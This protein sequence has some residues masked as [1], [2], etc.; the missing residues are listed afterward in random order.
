MGPCIEI[1][2]ICQ[3]QQVPTT[4]CQVY[5]KFIQTICQQQVP[6]TSYV[7][8]NWPQEFRGLWA[9][10]RCGATGTG[11]TCEIIWH[12]FVAVVHDETSIVCH[13]F[14]CKMGFWLYNSVVWHTCSC[15]LA[16]LCLSFQTATLLDRFL[17]EEFLFRQVT[18]LEM[19]LSG[20]AL[21]FFGEKNGETRFQEDERWRKNL[22]PQP[23]T[24][25]ETQLVRSSLFVPG[26]GM[27]ARRGW[28]GNP[29]RCCSQG[30]KMDWIYINVG[31]IPSSW[32]GNPLQ[33]ALGFLW[34]I[35][36][37]ININKHMASIYRFAWL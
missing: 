19:P 34:V 17:S 21:F 13:N 6:T 9:A 10:W 1:W 18:S 29:R 26:A 33:V 2:K 15:F 28:S 11:R 27:P 23:G 31:I 30:P 20:S 22:A 35:Y 5:R 12:M 36:C 32:Q 3:Q 24:G 25:L 4:I 7:G 8:L 37:P 14:I 16:E